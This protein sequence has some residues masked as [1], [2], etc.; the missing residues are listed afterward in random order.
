LRTFIDRPRGSVG[1][2]LG[3]GELE[4]LGDRG[5]RE[6]VRT[7]VACRP[8]KGR[9][10]AMVAEDGLAHLRLPVR[11]RNV[12]PGDELDGVVEEGLRNCGLPLRAGD[13]LVVAEKIVAVAQG[14]VVPVEEVRVSP[15]ARLLSRYTFRTP[16]GISLGMPES[17]ELAIR[18]VGLARI[19]VG[20]VGAAL[21]RPLGI[22]G[23]FYRI[24]GWQVAAIDSPDADALPPS[25]TCIKL[26]PRDPGGVSLRLAE[27]LTRLAGARVEVAVVDVN[28][29]GAE[30]LGASSG[31]N[32][33][34]LVSLLRDNPLGQ[35]TQQTPVG[36][37]RQAV[38]PFGD[39]VA[40]R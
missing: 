9:H 32:R 35:D 6:G 16:S 13:V 10:L 1:D 24:A 28:D 15:L 25:N 3:D 20:A 29:V 40:G 19:L 22:R 38:F 26:A 36:I 11:T 31:V 17:F 39:A 14:R 5:C 27:Q 30:I 18:E 21:T 23:V 12:W 37:V 33:R 34:L 4:A 8:D 2:P 7:A